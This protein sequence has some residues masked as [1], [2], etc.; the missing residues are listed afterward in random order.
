MDRRVKVIDPPQPIVTVDEAVS[1][2]VEVPTEDRSYV[3]SLVLA[4][5]TWIDG[6]SGWLGRTLGVQTLELTLDGFI[7]EGC[8]DEILLPFE[9]LIDVTSVSYVDEGGSV[10]TLPPADY[11]TTAHGLRPADDGDW[12]STDDIAEAVKIR[13]R[14]GYGKP[15]PSDGLKLVNN[16]PAPIKVAVMM[17]VSQWYR[18]R[19]P[20]VLGATVETLPFAVDALLSPYRV[21]R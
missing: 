5:T 17:L 14:A 8:S 4:A 13:Y 19:E 21:Y 16:A 2:L 7:S 18:T 1:H 10:V 6:P 20:V 11:V 9:P 12:P 15:D 3:E